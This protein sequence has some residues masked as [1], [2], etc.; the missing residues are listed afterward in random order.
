LFRTECFCGNE[1]PEWG[2][3]LP[4]TFCDMYCPG[5]QSQICGGHYTINIFKTGVSSMLYFLILDILLIFN[6]FF[7]EFIAKVAS[8]PMSNLK[9]NNPVRIVFLLTLNGRAVRQ[10]YRLIK[11]LFHRDHYFFIHIDA[12]RQ[13]IIIKL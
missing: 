5:N 10:V 2:L 1:T 12:V 8:E 11:A 6:T 3:K 7:V 4:D 9:N 13:D